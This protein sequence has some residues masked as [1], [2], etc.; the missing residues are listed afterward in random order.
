CAFT[1]L[2]FSSRI[3]IAIYPFS[4]VKMLQLADILTVKIA[5]EILINSALWN[6]YVHH[7]SFGNSAL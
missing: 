2:S 6:Y 7:M 3:R 4:G 1:K 5:M